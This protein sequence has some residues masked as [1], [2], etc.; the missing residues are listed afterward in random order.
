MSARKLLQTTC[1]IKAIGADTISPDQEPLAGRST[2]QFNR[3]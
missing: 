1:L 2:E 3:I